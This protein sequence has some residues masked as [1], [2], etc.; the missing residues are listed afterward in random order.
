MIFTF[1]NAGYW[2]VGQNDQ[3]SEGV[4]K[5]IDDPA[6]C[7]GVFL[8]WQTDT[9]QP[10]GGRNKNCIAF[11]SKRRNSEA[12]RDRNCVNNQF[13]VLCKAISGE[14][15]CCGH[16]PLI[17]LSIE[18]HVRIGLCYYIYIII[19]RPILYTPCYNV[20]NVFADRNHSNKDQINSKLL[21]IM[22][23]KFYVLSIRACKQRHRNSF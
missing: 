7:P 19:I 22:S 5:N 15:N 12:F 21:V 23:I 4:F 17:Q 10:N 3:S 1:S 6:H 11:D 8:D 14:Y 2:W 13:G 18:N 20:W 9:D 16:M